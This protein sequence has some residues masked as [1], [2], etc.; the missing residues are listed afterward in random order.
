MMII[1]GKVGIIGDITNKLGKITSIT[2][3]LVA[4][5]LSQVIINIIGY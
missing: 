2:R 1:A 4:R 3:K 5:I